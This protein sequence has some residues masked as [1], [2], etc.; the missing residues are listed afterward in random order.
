VQQDSK[1]VEAYYRASL[2]G[3]RALEAQSGRARCFGE[4]AEARWRAFR[5]ELREGVLLDLMLR[6]AAVSQ[7][8]AFAPRVV[9]PIPGLADDEP[10]G[11]EWPGIG[12][13]AAIALLKEPFQNQPLDALLARVAAIWSLRTAPLPSGALDSIAPATRVLASGPSAI[14]ALSACFAARRDLDLAN[15]V[16][17]VSDH[18]GERQ[19]FGLASALLGCA[20][21]PQLAQT[22]DAAE[23][24]RELRIPPSALVVAEPSSPARELLSRLLVQ[25]GA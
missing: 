10:F 7:P 4:D 9:F 18:P 13:P 24:A 5:G 12:A 23:R 15:Q 8:A 22:S 19:L 17:L 20:G 16:L 2:L 6:D 14:L 11:P 21:M 1:Q 3:L 25:P